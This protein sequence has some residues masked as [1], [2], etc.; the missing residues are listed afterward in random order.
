MSI[1]KVLQVGLLVAGISF[2]WSSIKN[3]FIGGSVNTKFLVIGVVCLAASWAIG[4]KLVLGEVP[5]VSSCFMAD[6]ITQT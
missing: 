1:G 4:R 6:H 5:V 3:A 2:L